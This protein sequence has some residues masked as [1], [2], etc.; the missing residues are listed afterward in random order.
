MGFLVW[1]AATL[2]HPRS[3]ISLRIEVAVRKVSG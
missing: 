2:F 1:K 3:A